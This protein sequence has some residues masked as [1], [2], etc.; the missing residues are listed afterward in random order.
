MGEERRAGRIVGALVIVQMG[1]SALVNFGLESP[2]FGSPGFLVSAAP[3]SLEIGIAVCLALLL[4][5][6]TIGVAVTAYPIFKGHSRAL[7]LWLLAL[8]AGGFGAAILENV[9]VMS[10]VSLSNAYATAGEAD[11]GFYLALKVLA[12]SDRNWAHFIDHL[13]SGVILLVFYFTAFRFRLIPR[14]LGGFGLIA[15][16]LQ[17]CTISRPLFG[18]EV[19]FR[20]LA[21]LGL[22]QLALALWLLVKGF[23]PRSPAV[24]EL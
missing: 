5:I 15:V 17:L 23:P 22:C 6:A 18:G 11:R 21:P 12:A 14:L 9:N 4:G 2:L 24:A 20:L 13:V 10:M 19:D 8:S 7:A 3:H 16:A 1:G